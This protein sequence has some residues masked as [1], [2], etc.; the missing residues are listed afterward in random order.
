MR[1]RKREGFGGGVVRCRAR[2]VVD[3]RLNLELRFL[4]LRLV[5]LLEEGS[6]SL[7]H[8]IA[9]KSKEGGV[10]TRIGFWGAEGQGSAWVCSRHPRAAPSAGIRR[11]LWSSVRS[12]WAGA[13]AWPQ[14]RGTGKGAIRREGEGAR[15]GAHLREPHAEEGWAR[16]ASELGQDGIQRIYRGELA[17][18][19]GTIALPAN[20]GG[21]G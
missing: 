8:T 18:G 7:A 12:I 10:G 2:L 9:G 15:Q 16:A 1:L 14:G 11:S 17:L 6:L 13:L 19:E 3:A 20:H 4:H 21:G 5:R